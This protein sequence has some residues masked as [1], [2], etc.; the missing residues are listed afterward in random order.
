MLTSYFV[1]D[2][3]CDRCKRRQKQKCFHRS[4]CDRVS[5]RSMI[6]DLEIQL[7]KYYDRHGKTYDEIIK[8]T[9][10]VTDHMQATKNLD[11][12][13]IDYV[14]PVND[15]EKQRQ[16]ARFI[17]RECNLR[18]IKLHGSQFEE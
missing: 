4:V 9:K 1:E 15:P 13:H 17:A 11:S 16:Y 14:V 5:V 12:N 8:K 10:L 6:D 18:G 2:S 3:R 7:G